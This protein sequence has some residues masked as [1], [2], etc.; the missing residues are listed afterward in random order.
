[1]SRSAATAALDMPTALGLL[2]PHLRVTWRHEFA[3]ASETAIAN[4]LVAP[5]LP[6]TMTSSR[7]GRDFA[8]VTAGFSGQLGRGVRLSA[9]YAGEIGHRNETMHRLSLMARIAF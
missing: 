1:M 9:D 2:T 3:D 5:G 7:L 4:F 8:G 6:F